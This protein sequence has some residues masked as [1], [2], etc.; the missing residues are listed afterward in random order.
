LAP[1]FVMSVE[2]ADGGGGDGILNGGSEAQKTTKRL[3]SCHE[4]QECLNRGGRLTIAGSLHMA[5]LKGESKVENE[6]LK[7]G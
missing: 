3:I 4:R 2:S 1:E 7:P 6:A 5:M